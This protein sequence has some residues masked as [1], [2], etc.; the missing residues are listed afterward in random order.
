LAVVIASRPEGIYVMVVWDGGTWMV[1][2]ILWA[3]PT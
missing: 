3:K 2:E 1:G